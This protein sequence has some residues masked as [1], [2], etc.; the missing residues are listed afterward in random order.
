MKLETYQLID[1]MI[2]F[3]GNVAALMHQG[4]PVDILDPEMLDF[5]K[6]VAALTGLPW[7]IPEDA[8]HC[9]NIVRIS[10]RLLRERQ[11]A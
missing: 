5:T 8:N 4:V 7:P 10:R 9:R 2:A 6:R 3:Y 11:D 1:G